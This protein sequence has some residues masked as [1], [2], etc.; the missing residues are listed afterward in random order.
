MGSGIV[1]WRHELF[2]HR[3]HRRLYLVGSV[4]FAVVVSKTVRLARPAHL[5]FWQSGC[6]Q[7][8]HGQEI[9]R[10]VDVIWRC[11]QRLVCRFRQK[12]AQTSA[13]KLWPVWRLPFLGHCSRIPPLSRR[14]G[15]SYAAGILFAINGWLGQPRWRGFAQL[16]TFS[17][18]SRR[19]WCHPCFAPFYCF[20]LFGLT[21]AS[22]RDSVHAPHLAPPENIRSS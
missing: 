10:V 13:S 4:S 5:W 21:P 6:D 14:Q 3:N 17:Y 11:W 22:P 19:H 1:K 7:C 2:D 16:V 20:Y 18:S 9:G 8:A 12:F 15:R